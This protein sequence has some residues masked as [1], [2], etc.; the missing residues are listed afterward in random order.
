MDSYPNLFL[1]GAAFQ[2]LVLLFFSEWDRLEATT[3]SAPAKVS[4]ISSAVAQ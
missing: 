3:D 1:V 4:M 2:G